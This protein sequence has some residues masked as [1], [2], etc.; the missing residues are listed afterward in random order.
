MNLQPFC[1]PVVERAVAVDN[2][3]SPL[4][5][6]DDQDSFL[7]NGYKAIVREDTN[8]VI[9]IVKDSYQI[10]K[11]GDLI[12]RLLQELATSGHS[13]R[14]DP[15]HSFVDNNRMRLQITFPELKFRDG[16]SDIAL[17]AFVHNSYDQSEGV[18]FYFGAIRAICSNGMVFGQI[19]SKYY[20]KHT[21]GF[22]FS[23]LG[24]KLADARQYFPQIQERIHR[25]ERLR[26]DE[27]LVEN[28]SE[29]I[30]KRLAE[31]VIAQEEIGRITQWQLLNRLTNYV[32]HDLDQRHRARYQDNISKVFAL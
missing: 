2:A 24:E 16:E 26:V 25:L 14:M 10:V 18:R 29:K 15:S 1:F 28:V 3:R 11:N 23:D 12:N 19:L 8:Q 31:Q 32:S 9:S 13:F 30:S 20:S 21:S 17:S 22:S 5:D 6:I 4:I 27:Q 7:P